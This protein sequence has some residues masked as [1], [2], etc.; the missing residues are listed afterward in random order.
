VG[1]TTNVI[2]RGGGVKMTLPSI[3]EFWNEVTI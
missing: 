3:Y 2:Y 1:R